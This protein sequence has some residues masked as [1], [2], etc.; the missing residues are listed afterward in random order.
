MYT[1][2]PAKS[3]SALGFQA[4][5]TGFSVA[6]TGRPKSRPIPIRPPQTLAH[7]DSLSTTIITLLLS[8]SRRVRTLREPAFG[9]KPGRSSHGAQRKIV[10]I[11]YVDEIHDSN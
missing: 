10:A 7:E 2:Y 9:T 6:E 11:V 1:L 5:A 8:P 4:S 3:A